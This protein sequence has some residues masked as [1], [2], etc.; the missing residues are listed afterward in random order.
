[1]ENNAARIFL[2]YDLTVSNRASVCVKEKECKSGAEHQ[3]LDLKKSHICTEGSRQ[4][5]DVSHS[6]K[7]ATIRTWVIFSVPVKPCFSKWSA[8]FKKVRLS[9][10]WQLLRM[11]RRRCSYT[12]MKRTFNTGLHN[13]LQ[14]LTISTACVWLKSDS[15]LHKEVF[16]ISTQTPVS[17]SSYWVWLKQAKEPNISLINLT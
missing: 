7:A 11:I 4:A 3:V 17:F 2:L 14:P 13:H 10:Y 6:S 16:R 15:N 12:Q 5:S 9:R 1:M 8:R